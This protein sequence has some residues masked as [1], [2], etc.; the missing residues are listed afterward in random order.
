MNLLYVI[1]YHTYVALSESFFAHLSC[2]HNI[3]YFNRLVLLCSCVKYTF[4][5]LHF[6]KVFFFYWF[7]G[8]K[9]QWIPLK[10]FVWGGG[11]ALVYDF[12]C[13]LYQVCLVVQCTAVVERDKKD[14]FMNKLINQLKNHY[15][16]FT[17]T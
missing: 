5:F 14:T 12:Q 16:T 8:Q 6:S 2:Y 15:S 1:L 3:I 11:G 13:I 7:F 17:L 10:V 4:L 9:L